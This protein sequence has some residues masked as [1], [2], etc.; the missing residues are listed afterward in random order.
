MAVLWA[1]QCCSLAW[2]VGHEHARA[3]VRTRT[4]ALLY[5]LLS[6]A[7]PSVPHAAAAAGPDA[8]FTTTFASLSGAG[9][10]R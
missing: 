6:I 7:A 5:A 2:T 8:A 3:H 9:G 10:R 1:P 4:V